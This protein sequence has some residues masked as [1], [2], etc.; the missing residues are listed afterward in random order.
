MNYEYNDGLFQLLEKAKDD[1]TI[2]RKILSTK[3]ADDPM[4]RLCEVS[5]E[6]GFPV[7]IGDIV[8]CGE[9]YLCNLS[10]GRMGV[11][12][13]MKQFGDTYEQFMASMEGLL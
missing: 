9:E 6:L 13:P 8:Q 12:E 1:K 11:T 7:T 3:N 4:K 5:T 2:V 10:D